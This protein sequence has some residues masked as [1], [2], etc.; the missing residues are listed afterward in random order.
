MLLQ[1]IKCQLFLQVNFKLILD[2]MHM[3]SYNSDMHSRTDQ[4]EQLEEKKKKWNSIENVYMQIFFFP[5]M[6]V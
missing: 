6:C 3:F 1:I 2:E 5:L 4:M